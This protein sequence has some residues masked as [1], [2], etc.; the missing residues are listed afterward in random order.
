EIKTLVSQSET[1][2][3]FDDPTS[4]RIKSKDRDQVVE[5]AR[6][7]ID[8][9]LRGDFTKNASLCRQCEYASICRFRSNETGTLEQEGEGNP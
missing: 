9:A 2:N 4:R 3:V 1:P 8:R 7:A 6:K 5:E